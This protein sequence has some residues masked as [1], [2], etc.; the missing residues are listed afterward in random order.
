MEIIEVL[1]AEGHLA[2]VRLPDTS[3]ETWA[4]ARLPVSVVP[5]DRVGCRASEAGMQTVL[6]PWPDGVPA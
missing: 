6:L 2:S 5:G 1:Q 4:L 3:I